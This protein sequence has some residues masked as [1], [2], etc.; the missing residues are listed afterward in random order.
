V[1]DQNTEQ[2]WSSHD[3]P[4]ELAAFAAELQDLRARCGD[5]SFGELERATPSDWPFF[6][7]SL[8]E[9]LRGMRLPRLEFLIDVVQTLLSFEDNRPVS[10]VDP[11]L[12]YWRARWKELDQEQQRLWPER[13]TQP[14]ELAELAA[15]MNEVRQAAGNPTLHELA[16]R[17]GR[18]P[19]VLQV[20]YDG[21]TLPSE[22]TVQDA[23]L[24]TGGD[25][26]RAHELWTRAAQALR[27]RI[28]AD[29]GTGRPGA[30][31]GGDLG[32]RIQ[33]A[34]RNLDECAGTLAQLQAEL[35]TRTNRLQLL[36]DDVARHEERATQAEIRA[37][38]GEEQAH[39]VDA[40]LTRALGAQAEQFEGT[41]DQL[42]KHARRREWVIGTLVAL[43]VGVVSILVSHFAIG[44]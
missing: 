23:V 16:D 44:L 10:R 25:P 27:G 35:V 42:E 1:V 19:S 29:R 21:A 17:T 6:T 11:R 30:A 9:V 2:Q 15:Y 5:P 3:Y 7:R 14:P 13:T 18:S 33:A 22:R 34:Q 36:A 32:T 26:G 31:D 28:E 8:S 39:A 24:A 38:L 12:E 40:L 4:Q 20:L 43:V 41:I 37:R